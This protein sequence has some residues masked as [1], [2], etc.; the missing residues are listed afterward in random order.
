MAYIPNLAQRLQQIMNNNT[1]TT[2][3]G[4]PVPST[5]PSRLPVVEFEYPDSGTN[6]MKVR[7]VRVAE[8]NG[9]YVKGEEIDSPNSQRKGI[10][11]TFSLTRIVRRGVSLVSF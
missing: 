11:K 3:T 1:T 5:Q 6:K 7:Y 4:A 10:F 8:M 2:S 9:D